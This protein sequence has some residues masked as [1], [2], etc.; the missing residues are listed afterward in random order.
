MRLV[1]AAIMLEA[2]RTSIANTIVRQFS[3]LTDTHALDAETS[4]SAS[5]K[6]LPI[7]ILQAS[8]CGICLHIEIPTF[9]PRIVDKPS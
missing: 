5:P 7:P 9:F 2:L 1:F 4:S 6:G 8:F 3:G